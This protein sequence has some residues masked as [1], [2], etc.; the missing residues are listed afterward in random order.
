MCFQQGSLDRV[1]DKGF[2][3]VFLDRFSKGLINR[4]V[5]TGWFQDEVLSKRLIGMVSRRGCGTV[6]LDRGF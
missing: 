4:V 2:G 3:T 6:F 1:V 5:L